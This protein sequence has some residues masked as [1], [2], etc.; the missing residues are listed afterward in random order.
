MT[1]SQTGQQLHDLPRSRFA[2]KTTIEA[3]KPL[4]IA[5]R[6]GSLEGTS[7]LTVG[8]FSKLKFTTM[9]SLLMLVLCSPFCVRLAKVSVFQAVKRI[10]ESLVKFAWVF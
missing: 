6:T 1:T 4:R 5:S 7:K 3:M 9:A 10:Y 8:A 2:T